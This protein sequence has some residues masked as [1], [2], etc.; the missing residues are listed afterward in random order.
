MIKNAIHLNKLTISNWS[1]S[2]IELISNGAY[3]PLLGFLGKKDYENVIN[4]M[5]F[6]YRGLPWTTL[7]LNIKFLYSQLCTIV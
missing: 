6:I 7:P 3:S 2:D 1:I 4:N 5:R